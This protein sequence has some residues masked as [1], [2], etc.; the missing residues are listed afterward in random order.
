MDGETC[1]YREKCPGWNLEFHPHNLQRRTT[2]IPLCRE[3][4]F[5][6]GYHRERC[7]HTG[8]L[9]LEQGVCSAVHCLPSLQQLEKDGSLHWNTGPFIEQCYYYSLPWF[10]PRT[11][12]FSSVTA[13]TPVSKPGLCVKYR[14]VILKNYTKER[15]WMTYNTQWLEQD[16]RVSIS[17]E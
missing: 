3:L 13:E 14:Y 11:F 12:F 6:L 5:K 15:I 7:I 16:T 17:S 10:F 1:V 9:L 8:V 2:Q 4:L